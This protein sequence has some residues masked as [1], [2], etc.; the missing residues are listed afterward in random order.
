MTP[1]A[2]LAAYVHLPWCISKCPYCDF[3]SHAHAGPLPERAYLAA[4]HRDLALEL[5]SAACRPLASV[6]FG[7]GTPSLFSARA[8]GAVLEAL[9]AAPGLASDCEI[10][11]EANPGAADTARFAGYRAAGVNRL[12][13]GAQSFRA[14]RLRELGRAHD[15][16]AG[17]AAV[18]A[19]R[20]AG[21]DNINL[22]VMYALPGDDAGGARLDLER[23]LALA[24]EHLSWYQLTLEP[25]TR[26]YRE[27]PALPGEAQVAAIEA[28]GRAL[29]AAAGFQRYEV[30]AWARPARQCRHNLGYWRFG[31]YLGLGAGA[32]GKYRRAADGALVR[33][34]RPRSP[35]R[36]L[37]LAGTE[38][39]RELRR[40]DGVWERIVEY[41]LGAL[42]LTGGFERAQ[43]E[44]RTGVAA[45][46][47]DEVLAAPAAQSLVLREGDR[48][49]ASAAGL[50]HLDSVLAGLEPPASARAS[51]V[52]AR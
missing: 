35:Q 36:Y 15:A 21:F 11:L 8:V 16:E 10:T 12:S 24:P 4:L 18:R 34:A 47:I 1:E 3:N 7:G 41:L 48:Y 2:P 43:F 27:P 44:Q 29:L 5:G 17:A 38:A 20:A 31:D 45:E 22:D 52:A 23:A 37:R 13:I 30:S 49:L 42:R 33:S 14:E 26:F 28:E 51:A 39:G 46:M 32:H 19:A 25:G 50:E 6:F 40:I 9:A